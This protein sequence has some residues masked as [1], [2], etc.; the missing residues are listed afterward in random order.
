MFHSTADRKGVLDNL[1]MIGVSWRQGGTEALAGFTPSADGLDDRLR[2]FADRHALAELALIATCNRVELIFA[3]RPGSGRH[4]LRRP[5]FEF[6]TGKTPGPGEAERSLR[7]WHGEG[8]A[9]HLFLIAAGLDSACVGETE[10]VGQVKT[11]HRQAKARGLAGTNLD[12]LFGKR[13]GSP[14][15]FAA[16]RASARDVSRSPRSRPMRYAGESGARPAR[17]R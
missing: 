11:A 3:R 9:E 5:V 12:L 10:I 1:G 16:A 7:A 4:D 14:P 6:L 13:S 8:A 15:E 2:D 17:L